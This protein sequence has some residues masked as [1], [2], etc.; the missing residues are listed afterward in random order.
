MIEIE[1]VWTAK[2]VIDLCP[3][4][5][6]ADPTPTDIF[7]LTEMA[8]GQKHFAPSSY[9]PSAEDGWPSLK[10]HIQ[11]ASY[12]GG[13]KLICSRTPGHRS[14]QFGI[15]CHR[16]A[17]STANPDHSTQFAPHAKPKSLRRSHY[18]ENHGKPRRGPRRALN[19]A[20]P[21]K[22]GAKEGSKQHG[23][24]QRPRHPE[25]QCPVV[26]SV[27]VDDE[28]DRFYFKTGV[29]CNTHC[30]HPRLTT[31]E[32]VA[33]RSSAPPS[34]TEV[35][36]QLA[37][38]HGP[39]SVAQRLAT[40]QS[41]G[42]NYSSS[43]VR[44]WR[45]EARNNIDDGRWSNIDKVDDGGANDFVNMLKAD[46]TVS[47]LV[48]Y[49]DVGLGVGPKS[50][51]VKYT[52]HKPA[53]TSEDGE[54]EVD[55]TPEEVKHQ[56]GIVRAASGK[57]TGRI[58]LMALWTTTEEARRFFIHPE[59][60][61]WDVTEGTNNEGRGL[62]LGLN[63]G[64]DL[65]S[66]VHTS[67]F[68]PN[69]QRWVFHY[70][71]KK[72]IP[73]LHGQATVDRIQVNVFDQAPNEYGPFLSTMKT[74]G[75]RFCWYHRGP[76]KTSPLLRFAEDEAGRS[77]LGDFDDLCNC[78]SDKVENED[79]YE[80]TLELTKMYVE[81]LHEQETFS[82]ALVAELN[83]QIDAIDASKEH[84]S[85]H[86]FL[87]SF[88]IK[89]R[90]TTSNECRHRNIKYG[91]DKVGPNNS[92]AQSGGTQNAKRKAA[93][94]RKQSK[95]ARNLTAA[96]LWG[97]GIDHVFPEAGRLFFGEY[98]SREA[99]VS[100]RIDC[101]TWLVMCPDPEPLGNPMEPQIHRCRTVKLI[102]DR[103]LE[104]SCKQMKWLG[105]ACR[106]ILC[107]TDAVHESC[108]TVRWW[109]AYCFYCRRE[110][111]SDHISK[112]WEDLAF[113]N[114]QYPGV[115]FENIPSADHYPVLS[116][117][118]V[119]L[120]NFT[121]LRDSP[122]PVV[123]N[124][125]EGTISVAMD[126]IK[127]RLPSVGMSQEIHFADGHDPGDYSF[128]AEDVDNE[129]ELFPYK[130]SDSLYHSMVAYA[131]SISKRHPDDDMRREIEHTLAELEVK[132]MLRLEGKYDAPTAEE[133]ALRP[134]N[135]A[136]LRDDD[137]NDEGESSSSSGYLSFC[138][139][140]PTAKTKDR[141]ILQAWE[142]R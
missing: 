5:P 127:K 25:H 22:R 41:G 62:F 35:Q 113:N 119:P 117:P 133:L 38:V 54:L 96:S 63:Y 10:G 33:L 19:S 36:R 43:A 111:T 89:K 72:G 98:Q 130:R 51:N 64:A 48:L 137:K 114:P 45:E 28:A 141:R 17:V 142:R 67:V 80:L 134:S 15:Q 53:G 93:T 12:L 116:D 71:A 97:Q 132:A 122:V 1:N 110:G 126:R 100:A 40:H 138:S 44:K 140:V 91:E 94:S 103:H 20:G 107:V 32:I 104:C 82:S 34:V 128:P 121:D 23:S 135:I 21:T 87:D 118:S 78:I 112:M 50:N 92:L 83:K 129:A 56:L 7:S 99:Y 139:Q 61:S 31:N 124:Y 69:N 55:A 59:V 2:A 88:N 37:Q 47:L 52:I 65:A 57:K 24:T 46:P 4:D 81:K 125:D 108:W 74:A 115:L 95:E 123:L 6:D 13:F 58:L 3:L 9:K 120:K 70:L 30:K 73:L 79:E 136:G 76:Q 101:S 60:C 86:F 75:V 42:V 84:V 11:Q 90:T 66:N 68:V 14:S 102:D 18:Q 16:H 85:N 27:F 106:H 105:I 77:A 8:E 39:T 29:G 109:K 26:Q 131:G 49:D